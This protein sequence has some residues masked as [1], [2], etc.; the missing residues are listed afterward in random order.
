V[1]IDKAVKLTGRERLNLNVSSESDQE[2]EA[3]A[4]EVV[5]LT[6]ARQQ[7]DTG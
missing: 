2:V 1:L 7:R 6:L 4:A 3:V 5:S